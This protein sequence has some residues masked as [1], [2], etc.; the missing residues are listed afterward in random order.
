MKDKPDGSVEY[1]NLVL[2][3]KQE[4]IL[5]EGEINKVLNRAFSNIQELLEKWTQR[6]SG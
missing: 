6:G 4:V 2:R 5:Q 3:H 1:T